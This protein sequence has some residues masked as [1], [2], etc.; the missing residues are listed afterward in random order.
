MTAEEVRRLFH[1]DGLDL[2]WKVDKGQRAKIGNVAGSHDKGYRSV[3]ID[4]K[5]HRVHRLVWLW[6]HGEMPSKC[7]D[8]INHKR[9]DNRI[10]NLR[11]ASRL[12]NSK[13]KTLH[14][15]N[16]SGHAGV[17]K[18]RG[19]WGANIRVNYRLIHLGLFDSFEDAVI[20]RENAEIQYKFHENHGR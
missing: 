5:S 12:E 15:N 7:I 19:K 11:V 1:Y 6:V 20:A 4:G 3:K 13:N 18:A 16:T 9:H 2:R 10:E 14:R 17:H 8:H